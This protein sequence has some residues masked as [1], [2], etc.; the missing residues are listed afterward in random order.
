MS[1][2]FPLWSY[3]VL[4]DTLMFSSVHFAPIRSIPVLVGPLCLLWSHSVLF[5]PLWPI[6]SYL[7]LL[8]PFGPFRYTQ[9]ILVYS[10]ILSTSVFFSPFG[11]LGPFGSFWS[12]TVHFS[13]NRSLPSILVILDPFGPIQST[14][15]YSVYFV[16][17]MSSSVLFG[18]MQSILVVLG[19]F[20]LIQSILV[21]LSSQCVFFVVFSA[22]LQISNFH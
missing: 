15:S 16:P 9:P 10:F 3:S 5:N 20:S 8:V 7:V 4:F 6:R 2:F 22:K 17:V 14:R 19:P 11:H 18:L 12:Y 13:P 1:P 21:V